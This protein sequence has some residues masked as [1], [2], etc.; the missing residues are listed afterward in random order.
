MTSGN[1][2]TRLGGRGRTLDGGTLSA[3]AGLAALTTLGVAAPFTAAV[4]GGL[5]IE[6]QLAPGLPNWQHLAYTIGAAVMILSAVDTTLGRITH[7]TEQRLSGRI[8]GPR[9]WSCEDC[10]ATITAHRWTP[11]DAAA[12]EQL[13]ADPAAHGCTGP[14][15]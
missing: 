15:Q 4:L 6:E 14:Q 7:R 2:K 8:Y 9:T 5:V 1:S 12:Y 3:R 13:L 10:P 11:Y